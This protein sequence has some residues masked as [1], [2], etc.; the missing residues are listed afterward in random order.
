M[1]PIGVWATFADLFAAAWC[2]NRFFMI[3]RCGKK[4]IRQSPKWL[5]I[6]SRIS[7]AQSSHACL[8]IVIDYAVAA[9]VTT[10]RRSQ[11]LHTAAL[12]LEDRNQYRT[13]LRKVK[14]SFFRSALAP[15]HSKK[16]GSHSSTLSQQASNTQQRTSTTTISNPSPNNINE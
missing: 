8:L 5:L 16:L 4:Q 3:N 2:N 11:D 10:R 9:V 7:A 6:S 14:F 12:L 13:T 1:Y 15:T